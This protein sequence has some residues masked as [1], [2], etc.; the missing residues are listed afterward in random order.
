M[1]PLPTTGHSARSEALAILILNYLGSLRSLVE[2]SSHP[3][4]PSTL[5]WSS[6]SG[7]YPFSNFEPLSWSVALGPISG[8]SVMGPLSSLT[9]KRLGA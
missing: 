8:A 1:Q 9:E 6:S 5:S 2:E 7:G 3:S 4:I